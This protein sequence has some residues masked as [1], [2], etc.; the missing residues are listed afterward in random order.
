MTD[1]QDALRRHRDSADRR[2]S[3]MCNLLP[4]RAD[5][6]SATGSGAIGVGAPAVTKRSDTDITES[7]CSRPGSASLLTN[8]SNST[9]RRQSRDAIVVNDRRHDDPAAAAATARKAIT[10]DRGAAD[11]AMGMVTGGRKLLERR[12][13]RQQPV[14]ASCSNI[15]TKQNVTAR[16]VGGGGID[17]LLAAGDAATS[18][19]FQLVTAAV[20]QQAD[21]DNC[22]NIE[23]RTAGGQR[24]G[25][26]N[27]QVTER[28]A[29][30]QKPIA[31]DK[32]RRD[33]DDNVRN[34]M[35]RQM[36]RNTSQNPRNEDSIS[37]RESQGDDDDEDEDEDGEDEGS[38]E[39]SSDDDDDESRRDSPR[40]L[41]S[42]PRDRMTETNHKRAVA[43]VHQQQ[44]SKKSTINGAS[45]EAV[46]GPSLNKVPTADVS[47]SVV[48]R[49]IVR[50]RIQAPVLSSVTITTSKQSTALVSSP[51]GAGSGGGDKR[52]PTIQQ[53]PLGVANLAALLASTLGTSS[54]CAISGGGPTAGGVPPGDY[55]VGKPKPTIARQPMM[56]N[57][58]ELAL[59][60]P[61]D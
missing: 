16:N 29:G 2:I 35:N 47:A 32:R 51:D 41:K 55:F 49:G 57:R 37:S 20:K 22:V 54:S 50:R 21:G 48:D 19:S 31:I 8:A 10:V 23:M 3:A 44:S 17:R 7:S 27:T 25:K 1:L 6:Q 15:N 52:S 43:N 61:L 4:D 38:D 30:G 26:I 13:S 42:K 14:N 5:D 56:T 24:T 46:S 9:S 11:A 33:D 60:L 59:K 58:V 18:S 39:E 28:T 45:S 53:S 12:R 40:R 34:S 36:R